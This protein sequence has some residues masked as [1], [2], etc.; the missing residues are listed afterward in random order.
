MT[1]HPLPAIIFMLVQFYA[2]AAMAGSSTEMTAGAESEI[3]CIYE[4]KLELQKAQEEILIL[5]AILDA[6]HKANTHYLRLSAYTAR[7]EECNDDIENTAIMQ[8][9]KPG[10][11]VAVS[12]DLRG[13]LGK[14]VYI[15][16]F[17]I[18]MVSD[19]MNSRYTKAI[20][21][22]VPEVDEALKIGVREN[23]FVTLIEPLAQNEKGINQECMHFTSHSE[24]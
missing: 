11:T 6:Y 7:K 14:R 9:P 22:L 13:W 17:G 18:R 20:D 12:R 2:M 1:R 19:L 15:E 8:R 24:P 21:I 10:W 23:V 16:G 3:I 4:Q 5:K